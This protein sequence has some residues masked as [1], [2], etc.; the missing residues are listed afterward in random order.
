MVID[1]ATNPTTVYGTKSPLQLVMIHEN[2]AGIGWLQNYFDPFKRGQVIEGDD[3][4]GINI[5]MPKESSEFR[6][7]P[8]VGFR[9]VE[10]GYIEGT[11]SLL[12]WS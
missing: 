2:P 1:H 7:N 3:I 9:N 5:R 6:T 10:E 12:R 4:L 11:E 8:Y